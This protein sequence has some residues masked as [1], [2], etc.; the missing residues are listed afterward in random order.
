LDPK[1]SNDRNITV[2]T[3]EG[4]AAGMSEQMGNPASTADRLDSVKDLDRTSK[5]HLRPTR[6]SSQTGLRLYS[7][8]R[9]ICSRHRRQI[10]GAATA[11]SSD[12]L[13]A[14]S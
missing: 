14:A 2:W 8:D 11:R 6:V 10:T 4:F 1:R 13:I 3:E 7:N 5:V 12:K 9:P